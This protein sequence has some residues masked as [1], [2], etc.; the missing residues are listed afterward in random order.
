MKSSLLRV[1]KKTIKIVVI[2]VVSLLLILFLLPYIMPG[3]ISKKIK[4]FVN[5]SID[6]K[7]EFSKARLSFFNHFP[8][9]TLTLYDFSS[10][11]SAPFQNEKLLSAGEIAMGISIPALIRDDI[12]I[13]EFYISGADINV[14]VNE[15]GEANYNVYK[16]QG[17]SGSTASSADTT[18]ALKLEKIVIEKSDVVYNDLSSGILINARELNYSGRG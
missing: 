15:K 13:N 18:T 12:T 5:R 9:L 4:S 16:S 3:T 10:T 14:H 7:I 1:V 11:G 2:S 8:S 17:S 6:G